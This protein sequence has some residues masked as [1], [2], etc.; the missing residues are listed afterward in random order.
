MAGLIVILLSPCKLAFLASA[1][2]VKIIEFSL[3][4]EARKAHLHLHK[5]IIIMPVPPFMKEVYA[6]RDLVLLEIHFAVLHTKLSN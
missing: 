3:E 4:N 6:V 1:T 5:R 2:C